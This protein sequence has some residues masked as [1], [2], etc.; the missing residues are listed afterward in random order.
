MKELHIPN[1]YFHLWR[2]YLAEQKI[3]ALALSSLHAEHVQIEQV[4]ALP[5]ATQSSYSLFKIIIKKTQ[6]ELDRPQLI[7]EMAQYVR[8]EHFGV[9]GYMATR[10]NSVAEALQ[11]ILKF[12]RLVID[13]DEITPIQMQ[14]L[15]Q[16]LIL[17]WAFIDEEY[18]L[19]N[20]LTN[21]LMVHLAR[22]IL[23]LDE[24]PFLRVEFAHTKQMALYHYLKFYQCDVIFEQPEYRLVLNTG[25][26]SLKLEHADASLM[27]LLIQ[28]AEDAIASKPRYQTIARQLHLIVAEYLKIQ[29]QAPKIQDIAQELHVSVRTLQRQ[30]NELN[31]S[32][33]RIL[34]LERMTQCEKLLVKGEH[35]T[36]IARRLG[37]SDQSAL[38]RAYKAYSQQTLVEARKRHKDLAFKSL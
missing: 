20:E 10:S 11:Y 19:I 37:Y 33:K 22:Q 24:L 16:S 13:G 21:A 26:L 3:D 29:Q 38:A 30:L 27:Q 28:Q 18:N 32:F 12:S 36:E 17:S 5:I 15:D 6:M 23:P 34:E 7:F 8:P 14:Q 2:T 9:L 4:L 25:S 1:G 35:L 31:T